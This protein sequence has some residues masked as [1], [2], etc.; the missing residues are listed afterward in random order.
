[1]YD[2]DTPFSVLVEDKELC[3][4]PDYQSYWV[5]RFEKINIIKKS[6]N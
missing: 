6:S 5:P 2:H 4:D 1:M 3:I